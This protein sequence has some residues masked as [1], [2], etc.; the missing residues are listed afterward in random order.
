MITGS[1]LITLV[2]DN[3]F[4]NEMTKLKKDFLKIDPNF[5]DLSDDDFI[6]IIL[7]SPSI[8]IT[9]ANGSVSHYEE[10]TLRRKARKLS[11]RSFFQ[12]ND[13][14]AP[15]LKYLSYNFTEWEHRFYE[16]IK[17]TMHSSLKANNVILETLKNPESLT[18]DLKRDILNAP[19][20]F[21]KF[22]SFLFME[23]DD[24]LLN[25]RSITEV[26]L[27]KIKEIGSVLE[28]DNVPVFQ[29]FCNSFMVRPGNVV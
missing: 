13:P 20:I 16:L 12:K 22:I 26:E 5:M 29:V 2:R 28:I 18:G 10:I 6:S 14:L 19:F 11:R 9:L 3:D 8:G 4:F 23:E 21:V 17:I 1:E 15:A 7:I 24:D 27:D 25:E